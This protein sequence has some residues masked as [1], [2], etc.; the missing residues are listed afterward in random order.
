L[1]IG[2]NGASYSDGPDS[3][4]QIADVRRG[5]YLRDHVIAC[6]QAIQAGVPLA[7]YFVWSFLD[8]FEWARGYTQRFGIV[9]V[10]FATQQRIPKQSAFWYRD[11][12]AANAVS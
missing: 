8:N 10:N 7:G 6:H 2:E 5:K 12:I 11:V 3:N 4:G 1:I 9:W